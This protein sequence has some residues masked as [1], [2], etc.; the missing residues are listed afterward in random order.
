M[1]RNQHHPNPEER[2]ERVKVDLP[3][4]AFIKGVMDVGEVPEDDEES[5]ER[6]FVIVEGELPEDGE[7]VRLSED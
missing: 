5:E 6:T 2:D 1:P 7:A 4:D 3:P